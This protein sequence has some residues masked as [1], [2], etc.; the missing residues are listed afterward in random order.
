M[1]YNVPQVWQCNFT[2][3]ETLKHNIMNEK[4]L[5]QLF[6][7]FAEFLEMYGADGI[8]DGVR[9]YAEEFARQKVKLFAIP[10]VS[11]S[12]TAEEVVNELEQ[13]DTLD[14]ALMYFRQNW[15]E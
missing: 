6:I 8:S 4:K 1:W 14:D 9:P 12:F 2:D 10:D 7:E 5:T 15:I 3:N 11:S 13:C